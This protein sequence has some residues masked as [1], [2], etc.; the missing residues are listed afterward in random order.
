M[1]AQ[2]DNRVMSSL[3]LFVDHQL[4]KHGEAYTNHSSYFNETTQTYA[5]FFNYSSPFKQFVSDVSV[6]GANVMTQAYLDGAAKNPGQDGFHSVDY[7]NGKVNFTSQITGSNRISGNYSVKDFNVYLTTLSEE[8]I[9]FE[10]KYHLKPKT[11][12]QATG[13]APDS[14]T[15]PAVFV[16]NTAS[17]NVPFSFGGTDQT[18]FNARLIVLADSAFTLDA[19]C[20]ILKDVVKSN[21][22]FIQDDLPFDALGGYTGLAYNYTGLATGNTLDP[23]GPNDAIFLNKAYVSKNVAGLN[24][25]DK[26]NPQMHTAFIDYE[27]IIARNPRKFND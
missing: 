18:N 5:N 6:T 12:Q 23:F 27:L 9:L 3:L 20:S 8:E 25:Y 10:S 7:L 15:F 4:L 16:K 14:Q 19:A 24:A 17:E 1:K 22:Y 26:V 2:F 11:H 21:V 13:L